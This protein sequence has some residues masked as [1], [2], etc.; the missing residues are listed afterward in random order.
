MNHPVPDDALFKK[1]AWRRAKDRILAVQEL[2]K[3]CTARS[4]GALL[5]LNDNDYAVRDAV[6]A[7]L[8]RLREHSSWDEL[9]VAFNQGGEEV[10]VF[11]IDLLGRKQDERSLGFVVSATSSGHAGV[12][13]KAFEVLAESSDPQALQVQISAL[14]DSYEPIRAL[15]VRKLAKNLGAAV[16][17]ELVKRIRDPHPTVRAAAAWAIAV[18]RAPNAFELIVPMLEDSDEKVRQAAVEALGTLKDARA[19]SLLI[20]ASR[21]GDEQWVRAIA[22]TLVRMS[23]LTEP[24]LL[25]NAI[26]DHSPLQWLIGNWIANEFNSRGHV[27]GL[28]CLLAGQDERVSQAA[29]DFLRERITTQT[30]PALYLFLKQ[31]N[32]GLR[33]KIIELLTPL[34]AES[35]IDPLIEVL[36]DAHLGVRAAAI[37]ALG[38]IGGPRGGQAVKSCAGESYESVRLACIEALQNTKDSVGL[39]IDWFGDQR[40]N[41]RR[42]VIQSLATLEHPDA[43]DILVAALV[44]RSDHVRNA[45]ARALAISSL[46]PATPA[47]AAYRALGTAVPLEDQIPLVDQAIEVLARLADMGHQQ[48]SY[49]LARAIWRKATLLKGSGNRDGCGSLFDQAAAMMQRDPYDLRD[50]Q[51]EKSLWLAEIGDKAGAIAAYEAVKAG[52]KIRDS[53]KPAQDVEF[54]AKLVNEKG[55]T[56]YADCLARAQAEQ[57]VAL[58]RQGTITC[59]RCGGRGWH[60]G[61]TLTGGRHYDIQ[62]T[63][64]YG[65][66]KI[67][68]GRE[69]RQM[70][71][72]AL[73]TY[74]R[75]VR[76]EGRRDLQD[77]MKRF[78]ELRETM[79]D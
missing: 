34:K 60:G 71:V 76:H 19:V 45:A 37:R 11:V 3:C 8:D 7:A 13:L 57:A 66:K 44:D 10:Q 25:L 4:L 58:Y 49:N 46:L 21:T 78:K 74:D 64:C 36:S 27:Q 50:L 41:L 35:A 32:P 43:V 5:S 14:E 16:A 77:E 15:A 1:L 30:A 18:V 9:L 26:R 20:T 40:E 12:R 42:A 47:L 56:E 54:Y 39:L 53:W 55:K 28:A 31:G 48:L 52:Q 51:R 23:G 63:L 68:L 24:E 2:G 72:R 59:T 70:M 38:A 17:Q 69:A 22:V 33:Q 29:M 73:E 75:L 67:D 6:K 79:G 65:R 61:G 62:C